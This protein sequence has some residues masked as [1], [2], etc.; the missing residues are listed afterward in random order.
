ME[1]RKLQSTVGQEKFRSR[2]KKRGAAAHREQQTTNVK[3]GA[4]DEGARLTSR[5]CASGER[6]AP[7]V[8]LDTSLL[9][10]RR[11][12][13]RSACSSATAWN[14]TIACRLW[15]ASWIS[16]VQR[17][18][19]SALLPSR[20][21]ALTSTALATT[22]L[23]STTACARAPPPARRR[24]RR[25]T[26]PSWQRPRPAPRVRPGSLRLLVERRGVQ[27]GARR[28]A[29][30]CA[31]SACPLGPAGAACASGA[32]LLARAALPP[33][34]QLPA[35]GGAGREGRSAGRSVPG[36][37]AS[38]SARSGPAAASR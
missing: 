26:A 13:A 6:V 29:C 18:T 9:T 5:H 27:S 31:R 14:C 34:G 12:L 4:G 38:G 28:M 37:P 35:Q 16:F 11:S 32:A 3:K 17:L 36:A 19:I 8:R 2:Y 30:R 23:L 10:A 20:C 25:A 22:A 7:R 33:R 21:I 1:I 15:I 24:A